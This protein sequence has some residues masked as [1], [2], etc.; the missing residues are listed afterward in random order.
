MNEILFKNRQEMKSWLRIHG[1]DSK[2][3]WLIFYKKKFDAGTIQYDE[4]VEEALCFGWIDSILKRIDEKT[5]KIK[6]TPR[7]PKSNWSKSNRDRVAKLIKQKKMTKAGLKIIEAA[8]SNGSWNRLVKF[9]DNPEIPVELH[10]A[11]DQNPVAKRIFENMP[12]SHKKQYLWWIAGAKREETRKRR[13]AE[14]VK[15]IEAKRSPGL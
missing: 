12:P 1:K 10:E 2:G 15:R 13:I 5:H 7:N 3:I 4:A 8:K 6:F 9:E 14:T 11:L